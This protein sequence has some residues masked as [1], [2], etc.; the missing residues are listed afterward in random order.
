[1]LNYDLFVSIFLL[2]EEMQDIFAYFKGG[3]CV[4]YKCSDSLGL[5]KGTLTSPE[6][7]HEEC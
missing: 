2:I 3:N 5:L 6:L 4:D 7:K 1:M